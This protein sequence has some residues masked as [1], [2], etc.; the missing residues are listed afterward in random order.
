MKNKTS[1]R[2]VCLVIQE[3]EK[4]L[5]EAELDERR[6]NNTPMAE[7]LRFAKHI[8]GAVKNDVVHN[9]LN[10]HD[11]LRLREGR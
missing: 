2:V 4:R 11:L 9:V 3:I 6:R 8:T 10:I 7:G 5:M 1:D